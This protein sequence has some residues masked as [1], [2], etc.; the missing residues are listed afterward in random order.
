LLFKI[1][2]GY[3][4]FLFLFFSYWIFLLAIFFTYTSN[5]IPK[6]PYTLSPL[7][8]PTH[9]LL[10]PVYFLYLNFKCYPLS[11]SPFLKPPIQFPPPQLLWGCM[12]IA[13]PSTQ[14]CL[15]GLEFQCTGASSLHRT[16][17]L[18]SPWCPTRPSSAT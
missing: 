12:P 17:G 9:P 11:L 14:S 13:H 18:P 4:L 7:C 3:F 2:I 16:K 15:P 1:F 6:A 8:S 5:T 10:L